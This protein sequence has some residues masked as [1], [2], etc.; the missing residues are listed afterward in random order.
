MPVAEL[1]EHDTGFQ[2]GVFMVVRMHQSSLSHEE[3][4][5]WKNTNQRTSAVQ[6]MELEVLLGC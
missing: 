4:Y 6:E 3:L 5:I 2:A 1:I